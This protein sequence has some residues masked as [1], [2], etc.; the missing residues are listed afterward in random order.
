M[1]LTLH[2]PPEGFLAEAELRQA[3]PNEWFLP[4]EGL[5]PCQT[6]IRTTYSRIVLTPDPVLNRPDWLPDQIDRGWISKDRSGVW[7][8]FEREPKLIGKVWE[9]QG[10]DWSRVLPCLIPDDYT[11]AH[12]DSL[13]CCEVKP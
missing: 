11:P 13:I 3:R 4:I 1:K 12:E 7:F 9:S 5:T 8:W 6:S 2:D 10:G